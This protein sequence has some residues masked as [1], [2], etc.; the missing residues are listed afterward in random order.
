MPND[1]VPKV[2]LTIAATV[3]GIVASITTFGVVQLK[4]VYDALANVERQVHAEASQVATE[5][6]VNSSRIA[7]IEREITALERETERLRTSITQD[8]ARADSVR[9]ADLRNAQTQLDALR[10]RLDLLSPPGERP[11]KT[12]R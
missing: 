9:Q 12:N 8:A 6:R 11:Q 3:F 1:E 7:G 4:A 2:P 5:A 10:Q